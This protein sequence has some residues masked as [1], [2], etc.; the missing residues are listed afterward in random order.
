MVN[1]VN[2]TTF[3]VNAVHN[4]TD[5]CGTVYG[6]VDAQAASQLDEITVSSTG[7]TLDLNITA[8]T[9]GTT[10]IIQGTALYS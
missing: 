6:I 3:E 10:A 1:G 4:G 2:I 9:D 7:T 5:E 8:A